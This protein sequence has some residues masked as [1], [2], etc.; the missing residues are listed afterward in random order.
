MLK[1]VLLG[2][3]IMGGFSLPLAAQ[4]PFLV[5]ADVNYA[6]PM[7]KEGHTWSLDGQPTDLFTILHRAGFNTVRLRIW[8]GDESLEAACELARRA[9]AQGLG[10]LP[11]LFLSENWADYVK[12]PI[13]TIWKDLSFDDRVKAV[14]AYAARVAARFPDQELFEI[15]NEIDFG[16]CGEFEEEWGKRLNPAYMKAAIWPRM[17]RLIRAAEDGVRQTNPHAKFILH[18]TQW[19]NPA[20]CT[21]CF[22]TMTASGVTVD[23]AGLSFYPTSGLSQENSFAAFQSSTA[24]LNQAT[25]L[26][27][28]IC[29]FGYPSEPSFPG[30]F[31]T[32]NHPVAGF[33]LDEAGQAQYLKAF[34]EVTHSTPYVQ[35]VIYWSPEWYTSDMW[36]AFALFTP[37]GHPKPALLQFQK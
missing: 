33:T 27:I 25:Q 8:T 30:Q 18:L 29:E 20:F 17:A 7:E 10:I 13:P 2:L 32:W 23:Y 24:Q 34:L 26:P 6:L 21:A 3:A 16:I 15:G 5:G 22:Q 19:W 11:V 28:I 35:G 37:Q 36:S 1:G 14:Q 4:S 9:R 12:Q 31:A